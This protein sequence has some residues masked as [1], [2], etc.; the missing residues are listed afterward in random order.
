MRGR[1][2]TIALAVMLATCVLDSLWLFGYALPRNPPAATVTP[3]PAGAP[4]WRR[5]DYDIRADRAGIQ[6][7]FRRGA[8][9]T[10]ITV[11]IVV[12]SCILMVALFGRIGS[13]EK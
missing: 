2:G 11:P 10:A 5:E 13:A 8:I 4:E 12:A 9:E 6:S 3:P 1:I 7:W